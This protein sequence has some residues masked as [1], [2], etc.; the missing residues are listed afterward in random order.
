MLSPHPSQNGRVKISSMLLVCGLLVASAGCR[1]RTVMAAPPVIIAPTPSE[2]EPA[3]GTPV[4]TKAEPA[5]ETPPSTTPSPAPAPKPA[6]HRTNPAPNAAPPENP[7]PTPPKT[8]APQI[9]PQL[10]PGDQATYERKTNEDIVAAEKNLQQAYG[11]E[12]NTSQHDLAE[13]INSFLGQA[14]E[15]MR[16][17]DWARAST[18][19]QKAH[20][21]S[22]ELVNSF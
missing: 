2:T 3:A 6:P 8:P 10:S 16:V 17:S 20:V 18:L 7:A 15:A 21:L 4:E 12:L 5:R 11:R 9:S 22:T 19:A 1:K 13:K 14:R